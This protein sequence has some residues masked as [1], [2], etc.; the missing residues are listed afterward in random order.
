MTDRELFQETFSCLHA[1]GTI[2][3]EVMEMAEN[4][5]RK[6]KRYIS[7]RLAVCAAAVLI[8]SIT[9]LAA[10]HSGF[11][12]SIFG[13]RG[14]EDVPAH[15]VEDAEKGSSFTAPAMEW[16]DPDVDTAEALLGE[17]V[18]HS[19]ESVTVYGVTLTVEEYVIDENGIGVLNY[20]L[21]DPDGLELMVS[22]D[23]GA[24]SMAPE[25]K[26]VDPGVNTIDGGMFCY[27]SFLTAEA[28][29]TENEIHAILY[30]APMEGFEEGEGI[31]IMHRGYQWDEESGELLEKEEQAITLVPDS[32]VAARSMASSEGYTAEI[33]PLGIQ[34]DGP[35]FEMAKNSPDT[36][37]WMPQRIYIT[38]EDG[39]VYQV[40]DADVQNFVSGSYGAEG[41]LIYIFNRMVDVEQVASITVNGP[42]GADLVFQT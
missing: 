29:R 42:D 2:C 16:E 18:I 12:Q 21:S 32:F 3:E 14:R 22:S 7:K 11:F 33:S 8:C 39:T 20:I 36:G 15:A 23:S 40:Q 41:C 31:R 30:F 35:I 26:V 1:S 28:A 5:G 25:S 34:F 13:S 4:K 24:F 27:N 38:Y 17:H 37:S 6:K 19:G 9:A 10:G